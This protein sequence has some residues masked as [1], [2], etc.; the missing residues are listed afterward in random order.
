MAEAKDT[1]EEAKDLKD[2]K[3]TQDLKK[4]KQKKDRSGNLK[5]YLIETRA[6]VKKIVWPTPKQ[7][8]NNTLIVLFMIFIIGIFIWALDALTSGGLGYLLK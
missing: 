2:Q 1:T 8:L 6:E 5:R 3:N 4:V 7:V